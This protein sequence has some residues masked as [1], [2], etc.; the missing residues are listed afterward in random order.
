MAVKTLTHGVAAVGA[1]A[2]AAKKSIKS[3]ATVFGRGSSPSSS[4]SEPIRSSSS[5][6]RFAEVY[7]RSTTTTPTRGDVGGLSPKAIGDVAPLGGLF[8]GDKPSTGEW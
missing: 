7:E 8:E 2:G 1:A 5:A 6:V 3:I 4:P